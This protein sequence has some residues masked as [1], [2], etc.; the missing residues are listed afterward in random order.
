MQKRLTF[1]GKA[2]YFHKIYK[3]SLKM[4]KALKTVMRISSVFENLAAQRKNPRTFAVPGNAYTLLSLK[5]FRKAFFSATV[6]KAACARFEDPEQTVLTQLVCTH[7]AFGKPYFVAI[8]PE[9]DPVIAVELS[10]EGAQKSIA[11]LGLRYRPL[12]GKYKPSAIAL[13]Y[14][15][16]R[17]EAELEKICGVEV[18]AGANRPKMPAL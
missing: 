12:A 7:R 9:Q 6:C 18:P 8:P 5:D 17:G 14:L 11:D 15:W 1:S 3:R 2:I 4:N 13:K 10:Y 16:A